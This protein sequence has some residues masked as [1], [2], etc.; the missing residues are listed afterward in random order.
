MT[1]S[2]S[3]RRKKNTAMQTVLSSGRTRLERDILVE[4]HIGSDVASTDAKTPYDLRQNSKPSVR[5][6]LT[7]TGTGTSTSTSTSAST[8]GGTSTSTSASTRTRTTTRISTL[9][10][11][12]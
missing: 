12:E 10:C 1:P 9:R 5:T 4:G 7:S 6:Q 3:S 2:P 11:L 8:G